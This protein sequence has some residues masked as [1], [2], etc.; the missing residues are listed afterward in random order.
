MDI[1]LDNSL[2]QAEL[3][4]AKAGELAENA[5]AKAQAANELIQIVRKAKPHA[6]AISEAL[7]QAHMDASMIITQAG[8]AFWLAH[9]AQEHLAGTRPLP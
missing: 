6:E 8:N 2:Q 4:L 9:S 3:L 5:A 1:S 7:L